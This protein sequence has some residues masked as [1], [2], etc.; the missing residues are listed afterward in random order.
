VRLKNTYPMPLVNLRVYREQIASVAR[1]T[2]FAMAGYAINVAI[3]FAAFSGNIP[4]WPL[5]TWVLCSLGICVT[6]GFRALR[7]MRLKSKE[8]TCSAANSLLVGVIW[9]GAG[10]GGGGGGG[11]GICC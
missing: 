8:R 1:T 5:T 9:A 6:I 11:G 4:H 10:G 2:P 3:A 7:P